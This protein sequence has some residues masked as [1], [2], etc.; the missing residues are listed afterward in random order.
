MKQFYNL[1][2]TEKNKLPDAYKQCDLTWDA[3]KRNAK[4]QRVHDPYGVW[5][6]YKKRFG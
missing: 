4:A 2:Y 6:H 3:A 1:H 5:F